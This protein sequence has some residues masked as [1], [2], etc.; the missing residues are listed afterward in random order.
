MGLQAVTN[1][2]P[3]CEMGIHGNRGLKAHC[4]ARDNRKEESGVSGLAFEK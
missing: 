3:E 1:L 2:L 4:S